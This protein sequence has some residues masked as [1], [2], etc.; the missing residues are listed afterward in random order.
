MTSKQDNKHMITVK[1]F[2]IQHYNPKRIF[3]ELQNEILNFGSTV[4]KVGKIRS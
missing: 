1:V 2:K 4:S 3:E